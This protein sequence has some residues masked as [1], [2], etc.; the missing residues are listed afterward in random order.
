MSVKSERVGETKRMNCGLLATI[1]RYD[2]YY[3]VDIRFET[4][5]L[6]RNRQYGNFRDGRVCPKNHLTNKLKSKRM[7]ET[8]TMNCGLS[9]T[10]IAYRNAA[11]IDIQFDNGQLVKGVSYKTFSEGHIL[12]PNNREEYI[13]S[14]IGEKNIA[15]NGMEMTIIDYRDS[16]DVDV[17]FA[18]GTIIYERQYRCFK[19]GTIR[20][21]NV[22]IKLAKRVS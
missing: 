9:A 16:N 19:N 21:P 18:D 4:G 11:D 7:G 13:K 3:D 2:N 14:K 6:I 17:Q 22:H 20:N 8:K 10:I 15:R 5:E 12:P 1:V